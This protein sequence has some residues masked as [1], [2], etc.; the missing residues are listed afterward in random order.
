M[1]RV[2]TDL[3]MSDQV[4][5]R[6]YE[7]VEQAPAYAAELDV[8]CNV[9]LFTGLVPYQL[10]RERLPG[11]HGRMQY[12]PHGG[13][14][15]YRTLA[16]VLADRGGRLPTVSLD[17]IPRD[18]VEEAFVD[19]GV[20][21]PRHIL[22]FDGEDAPFVRSAQDVTA[23][24]EARHRAGEVELCLT[25]LGSVARD[26][27]KRGVPAIRVEHTRSSLRDSLTRAA[28][29]DRI[30]RIEDAQ[31][32]VAIIRAPSGP[33]C[34]DQVRAS[35]RRLAEQLQ[36]LM[37]ETDDGDYLV[38]TTRG[39][40]ERLLARREWQWRQIAG[41]VGA[42]EGTRFGFGVGTTAADTEG[43][44]RRALQLDRTGEALYVVLP[45]GRILDGSGT[46]VGHGMLGSLR[47]TDERMIAHA[48]HIGLSSLRL[49][50]LAAALRHLDVAG[51]TA[52]ELADAYGIEVRSARR[53]LT[54]L[55]EAGVARVVG[56]EGS[57]G[58]GRP[59]T[60]YRVEV[61]KLVPSA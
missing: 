33:G 1:L 21:P 52:R 61:E 7:V 13:T 9:L 44:A 15:L 45:D 4:M 40:V 6:A 58:V 24:H 22:A 28:L 32:A 43:N 34:R 42:P 31:A 39:A 36:G 20:P 10:T 25:C 50:R 55:I 17:T 11:L 35:G 16:L 48:R 5:A 49:A 41:A 29:A 51:F 56:S 37:A 53:L 57:P 8:M 30:V 27:V 18:V 23:F 46:G 38:R 54:T 12:V 2:A 26:L 47:Q 3:A 19:L 14:D 60:V 59:Q